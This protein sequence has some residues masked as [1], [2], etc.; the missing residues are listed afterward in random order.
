MIWWRF[1]LENSTHSEATIFQ[2][3][4]VDGQGLSSIHHLVH[5]G[6]FST[7]ELS[8]VDFW[9]FF[10]AQ[11]LVPRK[12]VHIISVHFH[13]CMAIFTLLA[14]KP[15]WKVCSSTWIVSSLQL[16]D[17]WNHHLAL[18]SLSRR[19]FKHGLVL[20]PSLAEKNKK[21]AKFVQEPT[22]AKILYRVSWRISK[23][24]LLPKKMATV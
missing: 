11:I 6:T 5:P 17:V 16:K 7:S 21:S 2:L 15:I 18:F 13:I 22:G 3:V 10:L 12:K 20:L 14:V 9:I 23:T 1:D 8:F 19:L 4:L 24:E